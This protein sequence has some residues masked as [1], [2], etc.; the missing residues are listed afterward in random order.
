[1]KTCKNC[2]HYEPWYQRDDGFCEKILAVL[3]FTWEQREELVYAEVKSYF[4]CGAFVKAA[5]L[6]KPAVYTK[7][8]GG[9]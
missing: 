2:D 6:P 5:T 8:E 3:N 1:M 9:K 4:T 7:D